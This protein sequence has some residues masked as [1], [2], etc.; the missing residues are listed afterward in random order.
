MFSRLA[1]PEPLSKSVHFTTP[2]PFCLC[3]RGSCCCGLLPASFPNGLCG[4]CVVYCTRLLLV[5]VP[6]DSCKA[7][8]KAVV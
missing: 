4:F 1:I 8:R 2:H 3:Y 5:G 7:V 6:C